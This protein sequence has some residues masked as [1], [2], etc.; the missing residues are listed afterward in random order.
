MPLLFS[1]MRFFFLS[2]LVAVMFR[3]A[4]VAAT[5]T[6]SSTSLAESYRLQQV[7]VN[8]T[9]QDEP[10]SWQA[11]PT[12][13]E[14]FQVTIHVLTDAPPC[15]KDNLIAELWEVSLKLTNRMRARFCVTP[16]SLRTGE[17][18]DVN[19]HFYNA[20]LQGGGVMS[21]RMMALDPVIQQLERVWSQALPQVSQI[22][23]NDSNNQLQLQSHNGSQQQ[24]NIRMIN[25]REFRQEN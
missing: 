4:V 12:A 17:E 10:F 3:T 25:N 13:K 23:I 8:L 22:V 6:N 24:I 14:P 9:D 7:T 21:T 2:S 15:D 11:D 19:T 1:V 20:S 18:D 5:S 16:S